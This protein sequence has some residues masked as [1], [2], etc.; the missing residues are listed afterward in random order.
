MELLLILA[1]VFVLITVHEMGH[2]LAG[3][4]SGIPASHMR[5]R[6]FTFPQHVAI[7]DGDE[8]LSPNREE[9]VRYIELTREYFTSK[10][11]AFRWVAGGVLLECVFTVAV[12]LIAHRVGWT[13]LAFWTATMP[14]GRYLINVF[15]MDVPWA[16]IYKHAFGDTSGL[17]TIARIPAV[18]LTVVMLMIRGGILWYVAQPA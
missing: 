4:T 16:L 3:I 6:L 15:M 18:V 11:A 17:W 2:F 10:A 1:I 12:C 5:I 9:I 8:W 14:L 7:K 13:N